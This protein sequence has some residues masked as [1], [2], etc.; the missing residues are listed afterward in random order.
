M[1]I[2]VPTPQRRWSNNAVVREVDRPWTRR[3]GVVVFG[4]LAAAAPGAVYMLEQ[5]ECLRLDY[6]THELRAERDG[7]LE[8]KRRLH[9]E[10]AELE[11]LDRIA[12]LEAA[13]VPQQQSLIEIRDNELAQLREELARIRGEALEPES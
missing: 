13:D 2:S 7:L 10:R 1:R 4:V 6:R 9:A 5:S 3:L 11:S 12:E 8:E